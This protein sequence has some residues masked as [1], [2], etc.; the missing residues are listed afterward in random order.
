MLAKELQ[1]QI[2]KDIELTYKEKKALSAI[3]TSSDE[4]FTRVHLNQ[5]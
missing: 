2:E 3:L 1:I 4:V 5:E